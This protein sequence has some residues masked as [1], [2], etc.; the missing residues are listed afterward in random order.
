MSIENYNYDSIDHKKLIV[1]EGEDA[2][3]IAD[4]E[5]ARIGAKA[6]NNWDDGDNS[7][8]GIEAME[9]GVGRRA[10]KLTSNVSLRIRKLICEA[11]E[12]NFRLE[13]DAKKNE[14]QAVID[15]KAEALLV[16]LKK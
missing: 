15:A 12:T 11:A 5:L 2:G 3:R 4:I 1:Q 7:E 8:H 16:E 10:E 6:Q 14:K 13:L 9:S